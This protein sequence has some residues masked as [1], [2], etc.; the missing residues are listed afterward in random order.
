MPWLRAV[1]RAR[2][3]NHVCT[4]ARYHLG[5]REQRINHPNRPLHICT[6]SSL[7]AF[8]YSCFLESR[9]SSLPI[10]GHTIQAG[11]NPRQAINSSAY[12]R[13]V[14]SCL[15]VYTHLCRGNPCPEPGLVE[16]SAAKCR[17]GPSL[18][19]ASRTIVLDIRSRL[20][21]AF[22]LPGPVASRSHPTIR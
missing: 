4:I 12:H 3:R 18:K 16:S 8:W 17:P 5:A 13:C 20:T 15:R 6:F 19:F 1:R 22:G 21:H 10:S 14:L 2:R 9:R 11:L 7:H